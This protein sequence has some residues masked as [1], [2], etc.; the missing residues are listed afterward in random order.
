MSR[1]AAAKVVAGGWKS[2]ET[3]DQ[4]NLKPLA[5]SFAEMAEALGQ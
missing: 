1:S 3:G 2:L 4:L 5:D